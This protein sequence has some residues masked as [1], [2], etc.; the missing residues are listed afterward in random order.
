MSLVSCYIRV[1]NIIQYSPNDGQSIYSV[2]NRYHTSVIVGVRVPTNTMASEQLWTIL[3]LHQ[4]ITAAD[5][6]HCSS[7]YISSRIF[8]YL[9]GIY[10]RY[11]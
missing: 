8:H 7:D 11:G 1:E 9:L 5:E 2:M 4:H 10:T 6:G 3:Y